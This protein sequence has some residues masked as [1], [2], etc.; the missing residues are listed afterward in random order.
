LKYLPTSVTRTTMEMEFKPYSANGIILLA[1]QSEGRS[2]DYFSISLHRGHVEVRYNLGS[3][4]V[5]LTSTHPVNLAIW[6]KLVVKRY[7]Q[8]GMLMLNGGEVVTARAK[9][10]NKSLNLKGYAYI[11]GFPA[12]NTSSIEGMV[13]ETSNF[14]GCIRDLQLR[15]RGVSLVSN[16]EPLLVEPHNIKD[17]SEHAC[18]QLICKNGGRCTSRG[19]KA[20]CACAKGFRGRRCHKKKKKRKKRRRKKDRKRKK[21]NFPF[22]IANQ[23]DYRKYKY[24]L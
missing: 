11:G 16:T 12:L 3:G 10:R 9:G 23:E 5:T 21:I 1:R 18:S 15:G 13:A 24:S 7:R 19:D 2:G 22:I 17:C 20:R 4:P 14:Q 6:N 8:D